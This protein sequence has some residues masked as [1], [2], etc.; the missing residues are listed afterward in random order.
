[1]CVSVSTLVPGSL[2]DRDGSVA[3]HPARSNPVLSISITLVTFT[4][5]TTKDSTHLQTYI[6]RVSQFNS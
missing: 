1:M 3:F 5:V 2:N 4:K 6:Y